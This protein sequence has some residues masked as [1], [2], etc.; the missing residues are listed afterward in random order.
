MTMSAL[1]AVEAESLFAEPMPPADPADCIWYH[2][3]TLP[4]FGEIAGQWDLRGEYGAYTGNVDMAGKSVL[5][6]GTA[7][8]FLSFE[9]EAAGAS[10]IVS[11]DMD[12]AERSPRTTIVALRVRG[13]RVR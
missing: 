2:S 10:E 3:M 12:T 11:F 13:W 7:S 6:I 9:A 4:G 8:G 1:K 5:D